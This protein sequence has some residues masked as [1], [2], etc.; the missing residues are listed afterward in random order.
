MPLSTRELTPE[1]HHFEQ[2]L[3]Q[4]QHITTD[5]SAFRITE[6]NL[7]IVFWAPDLDEEFGVLG[8]PLVLRVDS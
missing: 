1:V 5:N 7:H 3:P 2:A 6:K 8:G 4:K